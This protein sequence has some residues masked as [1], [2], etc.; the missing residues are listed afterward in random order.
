[1]GVTH[2]PLPVPA[3][4]DPEKVGQVFRVDYH[5]IAEA[6]RADAARL[7]VS[8]SAEDQ[9]RVCLVIIDA[10]NTF[11]I[12]GFELFV[13]GAVADNQRLIQFL[14]RNLPS[15]TEVALTL[16][17][18]T[19]MQIF[20]PPFWVRGAGPMAEPFFDVPLG[21]NPK[22]NTPITAAD[23]QA[24]LWR[25]N[26]AMERSLGHELPF[27]QQHALHYVQ[28]LE[29]QGKFTLTIWP[30]H[31]MLGGIGHAL[32]S[33]LEEAVFYHTIARSTQA[34]F[35]LKGS[36]PLTENYSAVRPEVL[37]GP[38][39]ASIGVATNTALLEKLLQFDAVIIAGQAKSHCV[40][41][42]VEDLL[43]E[44]QSRDASLAGKVYLLEDCTSP[45]IVPGVIDFTESANQAYARFA[46]A[47][48]HLVRADQPL[49]TWPGF[50]LR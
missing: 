24:D 11:C 35:Q 40:A 34:D 47:G 15:I 8:P 12:P 29:R 46:A 3:H 41:W 33:S 27:L 44:I 10:Q 7:Q 49:E 25:V 31:A 26:P 50:P 6:A 48:M 32:V 42:T 22:P 2:R 1:M 43:A 23:L 19:A 28:T 36:N 17:T 18:H 16:D 37:D 39:G 5:A 30:Y 38:G 4:F 9:R 14:Y 13:E 20:H 21:A 45:V